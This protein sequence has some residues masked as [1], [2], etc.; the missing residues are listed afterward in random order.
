MEP[1]NGSPIEE[2]QK[3][4]ISLS[5]TATPGSNL[6]VNVFV[7][8]DPNPAHP[9]T[10]AGDGVGQELAPE[11]QASAPSGQDLVPSPPELQVSA[12]PGHDLAPSY[13]APQASTQLSDEERTQLAQ[14]I[15]AWV[16]RALA[17]HRRGCSGR[18][19]NPLSSRIWLVFK[20]IDGNE[21]NPVKV[22]TTWAE[23][24]LLVKRGQELGDSV[25]IGMPS[26][27]EAQVVVAAAGKKWP[28]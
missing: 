28:S 16:V 1:R 8:G 4:L 7:G 10:S 9:E 25:S 17:G 12:P 3:G 18:D 14:R 19:E 26:K 22:C 13:R 24:A 6:T 27:R 5:L 23:A 20:D 11:L 21:Y 15:G 2:I